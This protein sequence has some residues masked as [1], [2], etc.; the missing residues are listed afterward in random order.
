MSQVFSDLRRK[1]VDGQLRTTNVTSLP[2]LEAFLSVPREEFVP[3]RLRDLSYIDEDLE[4]APSRY[5]VEPGPL[6]K[7]IQLA[8]VRPGDVVL[9]LCC[10]TGYSSAILATIASSVIAIE[11]DEDLAESATGRLSTL[12]YDN[13]AVLH[14]D[15]EN[16]CEDE[17]P[18][19]VI[20]I[21][22]SVGY[23]PDTILQQLKPGGRLV[24]VEGHGNAA[25]AVLYV[26]GRGVGGGRT[27]FNCA[28]KPVPG[29]RRQPGF[30]F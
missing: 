30:V 21:G 14:G 24:T 7:M 19:D 4:V 29:F 27:A 3:T 9:D 28:V 10:A 18:F 6:A 11:P 23:V 25:N 2:V 17:A 20:L 16:G 13:V 22:G 5:L 12:G 1:M 26:G 15:P 8:E